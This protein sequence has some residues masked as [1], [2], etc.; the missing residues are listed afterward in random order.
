ML[1]AY[2]Q[3]YAKDE[4]SFS[5]NPIKSLRNE[6]MTPKQKINNRAKEYAHFGD[7]HNPVGNFVNGAEYGYNLAVEMIAEYLENKLTHEYD[8]VV[9]TYFIV[10]YDFA[11]K[12][13]L[14][15]NLKQT[16][17]L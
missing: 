11:D 5:R 15:N 2:C 16:I 6:D 14:I 17:K 7:L 10:N 8:D 12:Y 9:N 13:D 4:I 3:P 1:I